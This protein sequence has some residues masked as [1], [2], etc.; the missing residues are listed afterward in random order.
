MTTREL[1]MVVVGKKLLATMRAVAVMRVV[2]SARWSLL[3]IPV[4]NYLGRNRQVT[5]DEHFKLE[6]ET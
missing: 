6:L 5:T 1:S 2:Y 4:P 3:L